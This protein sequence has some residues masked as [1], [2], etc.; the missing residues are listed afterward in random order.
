MRPDSLVAGDF[1]G[2]GRI[3]IAA[4]AD[5]GTSLS[6]LTQAATGGTF[7]RSSLR[8]AAGSGAL[9]A[10][11]FNGDGRQD[12]ALASGTTG[13]VQV[14]TGIPVGGILGSLYDIV[15]PAPVRT[16]AALTAAGTL[17]GP[18]AVNE[19]LAVRVGG[20]TTPLPGAIIVTANGQTTFPAAIAAPAAS[21]EI[22][23][24][25]Q[26]ADGATSAEGPMTIDGGFHPH[27]RRH[28]G[29]ERPP[30]GLLRGRRRSQTLT[31][32]ANGAGDWSVTAPVLANGS[33]AFTAAGNVSLVTAPRIVTVDS[34]RGIP[35][36]LAVDFDFGD[37][38]VNATVAAT[39]P[40]ALTGL[41][42]G[43]TLTIAFTDASGDFLSLPLDPARGSLNLS[44]LDGQVTSTL[45]CTP[46]DGGWSP[47]SAP[48]RPSTSSPRPSR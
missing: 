38:R 37:G 7:V 39:I 19:T 14:G 5:G 34:T 15:A 29:G 27:P 40:Y 41:A 24:L 8:V 1:N 44:G 6:I 28:G 12:L 47:S 9:A 30:H 4:L 33:Y 21:S 10:G 31:T 43:D 46:A 48:A 35:F 13:T 32:Q 17:S 26:R 11:D 25:V 18:L 42:P 2:D 20:A 3:D 16:V 36:A 23:L 22:G 45:T